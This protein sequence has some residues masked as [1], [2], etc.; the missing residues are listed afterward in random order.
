MNNL[1]TTPINEVVEFNDQPTVIFAKVLV[2]KRYTK[3]TPIRPYL[4]LKMRDES[5]IAYVNVWNNSEFYEGLSKFV[6]DTLHMR[7]E[8]THERTQ[9]DFYIFN[10]ERLFQYKVVKKG[11]EESEVNE[12]RQENN[13]QANEQNES[14]NPITIFKQ[15][16]LSFKDSRYQKFLV[17]VF[18][19][20]ELMKAYFNKPLSYFRTNGV[21]EQGGILTFTNSLLDLI[22]SNESYLQ[23]VGVD[24]DLLKFLAFVEPIGRLKSLLENK[25]G[26]HHKTLSGSLLP[27]PVLTINHLA[28]YFA[29]FDG[30]T[31]HQV[32]YIQHILL[33][34][35]GSKEWGAIWD[36]ATKEG[37]VFNRFW[38]MNIQMFHFDKHREKNY[39]NKNTSRLFGDVVI[40]PTFNEL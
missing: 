18:S 35:P 4:N 20:K 17:K 1:A 27:H 9:G 37:E 26:A 25:K 15:H 7:M 39:P 32:E 10:L 14:M 33:S 34:V 40:L 24:I 5:G 12:Q 11:K 36:N 38:Q 19:D 22:Q 31:T 2:A 28:P 23:R 6:N 21:S 8:V 13:R 29:G 3:T 16:L 30:F